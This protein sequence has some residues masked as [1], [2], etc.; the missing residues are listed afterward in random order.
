MFG[1]LD[2][3]M[4]PHVY[5]KLVFFETR[6]TFPT[7]NNTHSNL[8]TRVGRSV[9]K[10]EPHLNHR[11][12]QSLQRPFFVGENGQRGLHE[13]VLFGNSKIRHYMVCI[14]GRVLQCLTSTVKFTVERH[15]MIL[16]AL[17][18]I[19]SI[20]EQN[21]GKAKHSESQTKRR[22]QLRPMASCIQRCVVTSLIFFLMKAMFIF[23]MQS[24]ILT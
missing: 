12:L 24:V 7:P 6:L 17:R 5:C 15:T 14:A 11:I 22:P 21:H 1:L 2:Y 4:I 19:E 10:C 23:V 20:S 3:G 8:Q 9:V 18:L 16:E 13:G